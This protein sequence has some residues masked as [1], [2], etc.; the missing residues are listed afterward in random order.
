[1]ARDL[2]DDYGVDVAVEIFDGSATTGRTFNVQLRGTD[3]P[4]L[5]KALGSVRLDL[6]TIEYYRSLAAPVLVVLYHA[7]TGRL[8]YQWVHAYDP[9]ARGGKPPDPDAKTMG[10]RFLDSD[11]WSADV[12]A[13]LDAAVRGFNTFRSPTLPLPMQVAVVADASVVDSLPVTFALREALRP[14]SDLVAVE[15]RPALCGDESA[16]FLSERFSRITLAD[17]ASVTLPRD[18]EIPRPV[19]VGADLALG[20]AVVLANV[21][22][23]NIAAQITA[24]VARQS[25]AIGD[26]AVSFPLAGAMAHARRARE[27]IELA[28]DLDASDK[29]DI[30]LAGSAFLVMA[31]SVAPLSG[32]DRKAAIEATRR[33]LDRRLERGERA[34]AGAEAY[35][36]GMLHKQG[37]EGEAAIAAFMRALELEPLYDERAYFHRDLA[38]ALFET[39]RYREAAAAYGRAI[40]LGDTGLVEALYADAL[41]FAG[42]YADAE[43]QFEK[44]L[45]PNRGSEDAEWRLKRSIIPLLRRF[46]GAVQDRDPQRAEALTKSAELQDPTLT[47]EHAHAVLTQALHAD[48]C[49][50]EAW[51]RYA[52]VDSAARGA[53]E[54]PP[55]PPLAAAVLLRYATGAWV[56]A[57]MAADINAT[58]V[59]PDVFQVAYRFERDEFVRA[60][61]ATQAAGPDS[62]TRRLAVLEEAIA[63]QEALDRRPGFTM[64]FNDDEGGMTEVVIGE[65]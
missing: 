17:V 13:R 65:A 47:V 60:I 16:V 59:L 41:L 40:A 38:G 46:G 53:V 54:F 31:R 39:G 27:A 34:F 12:P 9:V 5:A 36:V 33:R 15:H 18:P 43:A 10:L 29:D 24:A 32:T 11:A 6:G 51:F 4:D 58:G 3:E 30:R 2:T 57:A 62:E 45:E 50:G 28:D 55:E 8:Y 23:T 22:Q 56:N 48:S 37:R 49:C 19:S 63:R 35:N 26:L 25:T 44:Y 20:I 61:V 7:R 64:R 21:G 52:L 1:M 14:V 42:R